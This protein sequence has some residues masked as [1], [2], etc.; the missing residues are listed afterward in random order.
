[1][2]SET[3]FEALRHRISG[4]WDVL[5]GRAYAGYQMPDHMDEVRLRIALA[6]F[7]EVGRPF[8]KACRTGAIP[9]G[10]S[11]RFLKLEPLI[12]EDFARAAMAFDEGGELFTDPFQHQAS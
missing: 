10:A 9:S 7:A 3:W 4:A 12:A 5:I 11:A 8:V 2:E 1:M 6:P